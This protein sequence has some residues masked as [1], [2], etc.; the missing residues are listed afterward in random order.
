[1]LK[2]T[3]TLSLLLIA[4][5]G[6]SDNSSPQMPPGYEPQQ[7]PN[8][9]MA[10]PSNNAPS[11]RTSNDQPSRTKPKSS[12]NTIPANAQ[13]TIYAGRLEGDS[14]VVR[15]DKMKDQ[16]ISVTKMHDWYVVHEADKSLLYY[17][18]YRAID[19][20]QDSDTQRAQMDRAKISLMSDPMGDRPFRGATLVPL[21][22]ADPIAP[23]EWDLRNAPGDCTLQIGVY[24]GSAE[25]KQAAVEAVKAA[26]A[27]GIE[28]YYYH[29]P[30][31]SLICVGHWPASAYRQEGAD[32]KAE[33]SN[34][35]Q[36]L[37]AVP[38]L[39]DEK[40]NQN[41]DQLKQQKQNLQV[42]KN[43]TEILDPTLRDAMMKFPHNTING[44]EHKKVVKGQE[45]YDASQL[46]PI[47]HDKTAAPAIAADP[48]GYDPNYRPN[49]PSE[50]PL[51]LTAP[52]PQ[53]G[54]RLRSIGD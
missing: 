24:M 3:L 33:S 6:S 16:L 36:M 44:M 9:Q 48:N 45:V 41:L 39:P 2:R 27:Q 8:S 25:R 26:R 47:P 22:A 49:L 37:M 42:V 5:C 38:D 21:T 18:Y 40:Y 54:G 1:M 15:A 32:V 51:T 12:G 28:A 17:G 19:N 43:S 23:A 13:F 50:K 4:G 35:D 30:N 29:G 53:I 34:P 20:D 52:P 7:L 46:V 10:K 11:P 31:Q 14:H